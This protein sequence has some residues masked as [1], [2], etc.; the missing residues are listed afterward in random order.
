MIS[1]CPHCQNPLQFDAA[2]KAKLKEMLLAL[3]PGQKL[4]IKCPA[5]RQQIKI[6]RSGQP[7]RSTKSSGKSVS[8]PAPPNLD[9]LKLGD[10]EEEGRVDDVPMALV[11]HP[12]P[13]TGKAIQEAMESVGYQ[14]ICAESVDEAMERIQFVNFSC[15]VLH[16]QFEDGGLETS[17]FHAY[18]QDM[19]MPK[20]RYIFYILVGPEFH[21]LYDLEALAHSA[22]LVVNERDLK[23]FDVLLRK[24]IPAYEELFGPL[25]EELAVQG[26]R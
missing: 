8:P 16:S 7:E 18:M 22:N 19:A 23:Y 24:A 17:R 9:W 5:C 6:L 25:M 2:K 15:I 20:R 13:L 12:D 3:E 10:F 26:K 14:V 21:S 1:S 4:T 11:L